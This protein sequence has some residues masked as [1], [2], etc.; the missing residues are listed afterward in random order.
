M[1]HIELKA[2]EGYWLYNETELGRNFVKAV[3]L[4][5]EEQVSNWVECTEEEKTLYEKEQEELTESLDELN[6]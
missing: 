6:I 4:G 3:I 1:K 2:K 5:K